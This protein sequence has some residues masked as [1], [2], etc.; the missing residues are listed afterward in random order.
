MVYQRGFVRTSRA[1]VWIALTRE[2]VVRL[3]DF[4]DLLWG[5]KTGLSEL[6]VAYCTAGGP[7]AIYCGERFDLNEGGNAICFYNA[8]GAPHPVKS[9]IQLNGM[10]SVFFMC[11]NECNDHLIILLNTGE[12]RFFNLAGEIVASSIKVPVG[13]L[14]VSTANGIAL[15]VD[16]GEPHVILL[17]YHSSGEYRTFFLKLPQVFQNQ[18]PTVMLSIPKQFSDTGYTELFIPFLS[19][20]NVSSFCHCVFYNNPRCFD[21]RLSVGGGSVVH[22]ALS[23]NG[24]SIAFLVRD[25]TL[26]VASRSFEDITRLINIETDVMPVQF[27]WC[28]DK[29]ITYLHLARQFDENAEFPTR[30]TLVNVDDPDQSEFLNDIPSSPY[31]FSECDGIR[32]FSSDAYQ[33]LQVVS[34]PSRRIFSVG[35]RAN[36]ALLLLAFDEFMCGGT[37]SVKMIRD[38]QRNPAE[39]NEAVNDCIAAAGFEWNISQQKRLMRVAAFGKSFCSMYESDFFVNMTRRLRVLNALRKSKVG[40]LMSQAQFLSLEGDRLSERLLQMCHHQLAYYICDFLGFNTR[41]VMMEWALAKL[42]KPFFSVTE[43]KQTALDV[44][45]KLNELKQNSFAEIACKLYVKQK[46]HAALLLLEAEKVALQQVPKLLDINQPE[47]ALQKAVTSGDTD[48]IFTAMMYLISHQGVEALPLLMSDSTTEKIF[49]LYATFSEI[50]REL[51]MEHH[52]THP[53]HKTYMDILNYLREEEGVKQSLLKKNS[54]W[55]ILQQ[56]KLTAIENVAISV[57]REIPGG[58]S[59][60]AIVRN[61]LPHAVVLSGFST[62]SQTNENWVRLHMQLLDEQTKLVREYNDKRFLNASVKRMIVLCHEH[63]CDGVA[64][65]L[66][67]EFGVS[68]KM[69]CWS[70]LDAYTTMSQ[71]GLID[72]LGD[73]KNK[74]KPVIGASAFINTL[75]ACGRQEQAKHYIHKIPQIEQRMEYYLLCSDW[76]GAGADCRRHGEPDLLTQLKDRVKGDAFAVQLIDKGWNSVQESGAVKLAK[77]F[78]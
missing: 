6:K 57:K 73:V 60:S 8:R 26:C 38:L 68:D 53:E 7:L 40:M 47:L 48:L 5:L 33:F 2:T 19:N 49:L 77:L 10:E 61:A 70:M 43:E 18:K 63:G 58:F 39:M 36:S 20:E 71:W 76:E 42:T 13:L 11:W 45:E 21:L 35:S 66:K 52:K 22:M 74:N 24:Q 69:H 14:C 23:P 9:H 37:S 1:G 30:L 34:A 46:K 4:D 17:E 16:D 3:I 78:A 51:L 32:I 28:G 54:N 15:L 62:S 12:V 27:L 55:E 64:G 31:L 56:K 72:Q 41:R 25:G 50:H 59:N 44:I 65:R 29:C 67:R 75:L